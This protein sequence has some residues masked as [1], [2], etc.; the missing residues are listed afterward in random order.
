M[1]RLTKLTRSFRFRIA[2]LSSLLSGTTLVGFG[3]V[4]WHL[5]YNAKINQ[6]DNII[7]NQLK[8]APISFK[9]TNP[10]SDSAWQRYESRLDAVLRIKDTESAILVMTPEGKLQYQSQNWPAPLPPRLLAQANDRSFFLP[11]PQAS[12]P[13]RPRDR[14]SSPLHREPP[15][16]PPPEPSLSPT[17][18]TDGTWRMIAAQIPHTKIVIGIDLHSIDTEMSAI[19]QIFMI[20][21]PLAW[22]FIGCG[23]WFLSGSAL[24][25]IQQLTQVIQQVS[26]KDLGQRLA[27]DTMSWEFE[28]LV[29]VFNQMLARLEQSFQQASRFSGDAAHELKTPLTILQGELEQALQQ[30]ETE[31]PQQQQ[32]SN[33]LD[34][35]RRLSSI[36]RKLLLL[37]FADAGQMQL[38]SSKVNI[39]VMLGEIL[40]D[41]EF[42][43]NDLTVTTTIADELWILG[44]RDLLTQVVQNLISNAIKYNLPAGW[45]K[46]QAYQEDESVYMTV[47]NASQ[48]IREADR[49]RLFDRFYRGDPSRTRKVD[50]VGLGLSLSREIVRAHHGDLILELSQPDQT[51][52]TLKLPRE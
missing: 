2:I 48:P 5:I 35:V 1:K 17:Y 24:R 52:F 50:G 34:E 44:D 14:G 39:S 51:V 26:S 22:L 37:S 46:I 33:L 40:E 49:Q 10:T 47:S 12:L 45:I 7:T 27:S 6:I 28:E 11:V 29:T 41:I 16:E 8:R 13:P 9:S 18:Q 32:L 3:I 4:A 21:I 43:A 23:A 30:A 36:V 15:G 25:P 20:S 42:I 19:R 31:S 38:S